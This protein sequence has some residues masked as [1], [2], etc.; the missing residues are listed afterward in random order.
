MPFLRDYTCQDGHKTEHL[1]MG[2]AETAPVTISC[3][4]CG[5]DAVP[6]LACWVRKPG[7]IDLRHYKLKTTP[8]APSKRQQTYVQGELGPAPAAP[9]FPIT[10]PPR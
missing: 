4:A 7:K 3:G 5:L 1:H 2:G 6:A 10:L 8:D 9:A